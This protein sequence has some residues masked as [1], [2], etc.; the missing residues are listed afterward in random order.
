MTEKTFQEV[1]K[2]GGIAL[3]IS[4]ILNV[5]VVMKHVEVYRVAIRVDAQAQQLALREQAEQSVAQEFAARANNDPQIAA[6]FK[7][8]Q[9]A[10]ASSAPSASVNHQPIPAP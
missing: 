1:V 7:R 6:I 2:Y 9:A 4:A 8:V 10:V 3:G 5:W